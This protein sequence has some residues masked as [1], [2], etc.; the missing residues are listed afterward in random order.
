VTNLTGQPGDRRVTLSWVAPGDTGGSPV[1]DYVVQYR[2]HATLQS[3]QPFTDGVSAATQATVTGLE[4][5]TSYRF[6]V[7]A[8]TAAGTSTNWT[9]LADITPA[10]VPGIPTGVVVEPADGRVALA[11]S[12][13]NN[14]GAVIT[15][16]LVEY[17]T[18]VAGSVWQVFGDGVSAGTS[19]TV[20]G[21]T[22]GTAYLF[23]VTAVNAI[24][25]GQPSAESSA[26]TPGPQAPA[27]T[28]LTGRAG[29]SSVALV[30][31]APTV[32]RGQQIVDYAIDFRLI[33]GDVPG[34]W[35]RANDG[36]S[37]ATQATV[38][39]LQNGATYEF[40]VAAVTTPGGIVGVFSDA[41][42]RHTPQALPPAPL[43]LSA[44]KR[45]STSVALS[46]TPPLAVARSTGPA[47]TGYVVQYRE[48]TSSRWVT[49][50]VAASAT[51][52]LISKLSSR[53]SYV[54]RV[55]A[56]SAAGLG[57]FTSEVRA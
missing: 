23:R 25:Q 30:W 32:V 5:G 20:T 15:D 54:F 50:E 48:T 9:V 7:A 46:W 11:W 18:N 12:A 44:K 19:T 4:N 40:R 52:Q 3:W 36:V 2:T 43:S 45:T 28:R 38:T 56:R 49:R 47:I 42:A 35:Q 22:N 24:G 51:S 31:T 13:P 26:A 33:T 55:A 17:R 53:K 8:V 41:S 27:P 1:T 14:G 39:G 34:A 16:Y 57:S 10:T 29:D 21:L 6:R 37:T